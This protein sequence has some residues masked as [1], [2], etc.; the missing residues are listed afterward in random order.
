[1]AAAQHNEDEFFSTALAL[2]KKA[3]R[4]VR[5]AFDQP[6]S[7]V[8]TKA[9]ATDLVTET[10][11]AVEEMLIKGLS[12]KFIGEESVS[13]GKRADYTEQPT[14]IIDPIDGTT[15]FVHRIP[16]IAICV[17]LAVKK[18]LRAGIVYN[19]ITYELFTAQAGKG[20]FKNGFPIHVSKTEAV[21]K[22]VMCSSLGIHNLPTLGE[23][24]LDTALNN[25][26]KT[27]LAGVRGH[28]AFG[29]A[30]LHMVYVAQGS[31]DAYVEYGLHSWDIAAAAVIVKEAGGVL[32]DPTGKEFDVMARKVLCGGTEKICRELSEMLT[33]VD[34]D[35]E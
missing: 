32:M 15:N 12:E 28:R 22:A 4:L 2:V 35:P 33:H 23:P 3:G 6:F 9:S 19:P 29:S 21:N 11:K 14:W 24:W 25:N 13:A 20:A 17:G 7:H 5:D 18:Q 10:D 30:A 34:F 8:E 16:Q 31:I 1:M 26:K 27:T